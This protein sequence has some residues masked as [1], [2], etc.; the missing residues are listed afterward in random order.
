[1]VEGWLE[2]EEDELD[3]QQPSVSTKRAP[4]DPPR[5]SFRKEER[6]PTVLSAPAPNRLAPKGVFYGAPE[7]KK[8][9]K[10][11]VYE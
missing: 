9:E 5:C 11:D 2:E 1:M 8:E 3:E 6:R 4:E 7:E 10:E